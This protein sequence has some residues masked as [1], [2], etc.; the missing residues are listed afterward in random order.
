M[1][2]QR[3]VAVLVGSLRRESFTRK[4]ANALMKLAP[5]SLLLEIVEIGEV[6]LY[7][8]GSRA[9]PSARLAGA[10]REVA[11]RRCRPVCDAGV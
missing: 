5:P 9:Q 6:S 1:A 3:K 11:R 4:V 2:N 8:P 7:K 10:A